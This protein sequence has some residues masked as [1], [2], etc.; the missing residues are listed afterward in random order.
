MRSILAALL[1]VWVVFGCGAA[2]MGGAPSG[3]DGAAGPAS[4]AMALDGLFLHDACTGVE[5]TQPDT[6]LHEQVL[7]EVLEVGGESGA[8]Y[9]VTLRVRGLFEPTTI[10]GGEAPL[11]AHPYFVVGGT[12]A[13]RDW[14][15]WHIEVSDPA[16]TYWLN[17]YPST[18]HTIYKEDF[19]APIVVAGGARVTVRVVDGNNRQMDNSEEGRADRRQVIEGVTPDV[20]DGQMLRLDVVRVQERE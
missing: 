4:V 7:E 6:C 10:E 5:P 14:S 13:A 9:D 2:D 18:S 15:H 16:E 3:T 20:L 19:E 8:L 11:S 17:H 12:V 1:V